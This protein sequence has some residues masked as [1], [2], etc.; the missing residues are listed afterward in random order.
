MVVYLHD[1]KLAFTQ[2]I[3]IRQLDRTI[4]TDTPS[5]SINVLKC[6]RIWWKF[7]EPFHSVD[8]GKKVVIVP[9]GVSKFLPV[10]RRN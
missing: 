2:P 9:A 4:S 6:L 5:I 7:A 3:C 10:Y 8:A 1:R